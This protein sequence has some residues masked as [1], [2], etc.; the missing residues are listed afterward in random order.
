MVKINKIMHVKHLA[1]CLAW[2][3][4][5]I[6][7]ICAG[8]RFLSLSSNPLLYSL[9]C[10]AGSI[11]DS[12]DHISALPAAP[13]WTL[14]MR[15]REGHHK[16]GAGRRNLLFPRAA[17]QQCSLI[18]TEVVPSW[19]SLNPVCRLPL[20]HRSSLIAAVSRQ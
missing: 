2:S 11:W 5:L 14:P 12:T 1:L 17:H 8:Y 18:S 15:K 13:C 3:G 9:L 4:C 7:G 10:G 6:P 20:T 16:T 19:R